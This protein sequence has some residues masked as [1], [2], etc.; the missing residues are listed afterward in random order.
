M[1]YIVYGGELDVVGQ[2]GFRD[3]SE[4]EF[5]GVYP[6]YPEAR[7]AWKGRAQ[8]TVDNA[9]MRF[10]IADRHVSLPAQVREP[11]SD[12]CDAQRPA[13][14]YVFRDYDEYYAT[15]GPNDPHGFGAR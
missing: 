10:Y 7:D 3:P 12:W 2:E 8:R 1:R 9:H 15:G 11:F 6:T 4:I 13:L 14:V 5:V